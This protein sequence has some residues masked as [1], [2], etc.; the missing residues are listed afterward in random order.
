[1]VPLPSA[2]LTCTLQLKNP[3]TAD[4]LPDF[5]QLADVG[6]MAPSTI[7]DGLRQMLPYL[8]QVSGAEDWG[9]MWGPGILSVHCGCLHVLLVRPAPSGTA[10]GRCCPTWQQ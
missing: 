5:Q 9:C 8:A 1:M 4:E 3:D 7:R 2:L 6:G 10:C